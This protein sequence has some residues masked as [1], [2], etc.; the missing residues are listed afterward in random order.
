MSGKKKGRKNHNVE[1]LILATALIPV[2]YTHLDVYKRQVQY[3]WR[4]PLNRTRL[5]RPRTTLAPMTQTTRTFATP[6]ARGR[7]P[8]ITSTL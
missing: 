5:N 7:L 8:N 3:G 4:L 1:K 6:T 2:S